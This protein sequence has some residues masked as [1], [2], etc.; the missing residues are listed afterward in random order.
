MMLSMVLI[1]VVVVLTS[2]LGLYILAGRNSQAGTPSWCE[3]GLLQEVKNY[4]TGGMCWWP[5][6]CPTVTHYNV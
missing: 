2:S 6:A 5:P 1:L 4:I 3:G